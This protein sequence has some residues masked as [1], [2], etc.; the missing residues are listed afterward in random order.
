MANEKKSVAV[1]V[2]VTPELHAV[3]EA[4]AEQADVSVAHVIRTAIR[5]YLTDQEA[6]S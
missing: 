2:N 1:R 4:K 5:F 3:L 6:T